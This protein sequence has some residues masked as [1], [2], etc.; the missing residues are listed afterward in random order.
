MAERPKE[1]RAEI[2]KLTAI[3][4]MP[5]LARRIVAL[6]PSPDVGELVSI[7]E[8][9]PGLAGQ[10]VRQANSPFFGYRGTVK[11][12]ADAI[13]RVLGVEPAVH[14]ALGGIAGKAMRVL[15]MVRWVARPCGC[16]PPTAPP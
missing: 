5:E 2:E 12:V 6:G 10:M 3:P 14:L 8:L 9:D 13:T 7:V 11:S 4:A 16:M 1:I 15:P